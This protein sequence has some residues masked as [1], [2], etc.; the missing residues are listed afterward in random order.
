MRVKEIYVIYQI[1]EYHMYQ[2][3]GKV[4]QGLPY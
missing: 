4:Y 3:I 2:L 1:Q